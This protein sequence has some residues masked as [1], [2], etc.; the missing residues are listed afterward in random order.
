[1]I[2]NTLGGGGT[3]ITK[4]IQSELLAI[5]AIN[6]NAQNAITL[7]NKAEQFTL[8]LNTS[9]YT[10]LRVVVNNNNGSTNRNIVSIEQ[11]NRLYKVTFQSGTAE[12]AAKDVPYTYITL[13]RS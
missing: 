5:T 4:T 6:A 2:L 3:G 9:S 10:R 13:P 7:Y 11:P 12:G 8:T 1:M